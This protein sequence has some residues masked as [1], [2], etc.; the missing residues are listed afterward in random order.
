[1][2]PRSSASLTTYSAMGPL[3]V[4]RDAP[5]GWAGSIP[6]LPI[7]PLGPTAHGR[8]RAFQL[9]LSS[10]C[11]VSPSSKEISDPLLHTVI[12]ALSAASQATAERYPWG[13]L[14]AAL[15]CFPPSEV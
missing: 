1:M 9:P 6:S 15:Q 11:Q 12:Q 7:W 3:P 10:H 14:W 5:L 13:G 2:R 8:L 4:Y